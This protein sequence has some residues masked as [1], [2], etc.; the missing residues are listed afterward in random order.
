MSEIFRHQN[1]KSSVYH[2]IETC[3]G[4]SRV[5]AP[6]E[7]FSVQFASPMR[8]RLE[9]A[10]M[11]SVDREVRQTDGSRQYEVRSKNAPV[12]LYTV[13]ILDYEFM[14]CSCGNVQFAGFMFVDIFRSHVS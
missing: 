10:Q 9:N 6:E 5:V 14:Q 13:E 3:E 7:Q 1:R 12:A 8:V 2:S 4:A 11:S